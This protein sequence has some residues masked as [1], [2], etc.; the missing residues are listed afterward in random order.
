MATNK[1]TGNTGGNTQDSSKEVEQLKKANAALEKKHN[2]LSKKVDALL[3]KP[4]GGSIKTKAEVK[5]AF[6]PSG[7][8]VSV[9]YKE[10]GKGDEKTAKFEV[11]VHA[12]HV[13]GVT[14]SDS[15]ALA[16]EAVMKYL[17][18]ET[19]KGGKSKYIREVFKS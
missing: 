6:K 8:S 13:K 10:G 14:Y 1:N 7:K 12:V 2:E 19:Y 3:K 9:T 15:E 16:N 18:E 5:P 17:A 4:A 11:I